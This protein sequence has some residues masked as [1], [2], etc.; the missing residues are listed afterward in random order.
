LEKLRIEEEAH[1]ATKT[2]YINMFS[3]GSIE[4]NE[5]LN[6]SKSFVRKMAYRDRINKQLRKDNLL[7]FEKSSEEKSK[8]EKIKAINNYGLELSNKILEMKELE[9]RLN[10]YKTGNSRE[11]EFE[12]T[13]RLKKGD[14]VI[15]KD[16]KVVK[17]K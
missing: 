10:A 11:Y 16:Y 2:E 9:A 13:E 1:E 7:L 8:F 3:K 17:A 15:I 12:V 4:I 5:L 14:K 6:K